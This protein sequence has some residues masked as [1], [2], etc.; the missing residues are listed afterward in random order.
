M[1][2]LVRILTPCIFKPSNRDRA[3]QNRTGQY[4]GD[5]EYTMNTACS[6]LGKYCCCSTVSRDMVGVALGTPHV[7]Q[8]CVEASVERVVVFR[9]CS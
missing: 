3:E 6:I 4:E 2:F 8:E 9:V 7:S 1:I 5:Y